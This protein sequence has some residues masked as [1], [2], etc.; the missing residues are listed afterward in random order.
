MLRARTLTGAL[1]GLRG[2]VAP[3]ELVREGIELLTAELAVYERTVRLMKAS[4]ARNITQLRAATVMAADA[5]Q[6]AM[7]AT[8][9]ERISEIQRAIDTKVPL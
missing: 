3:S 2:N 1:A 4:G 8:L 9:A 5:Q 7:I 6:R